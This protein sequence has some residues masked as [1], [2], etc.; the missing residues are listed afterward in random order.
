MI[1]CA[2]LRLELLRH[3][4]RQNHHQDNLHAQSIQQQAARTANQ[5]PVFSDFGPISAAF[6]N[7]ARTVLFQLTV[8]FLVLLSGLLGEFY[9][10]FRAM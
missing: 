8:C 6:N 1:D 7:S 5:S 10:K 9:R 3:H 4:V 2:Q